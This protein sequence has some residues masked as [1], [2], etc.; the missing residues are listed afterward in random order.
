MEPFAKITDAEYKVMRVVWDLGEVTS[1]Q[2]IQEVEKT[3]A[4]SPKTV[5]TLIARLVEKGALRIERTEG[6]THWYAAVVTEEDYRRYV[7]GSVLERLYG[8]S[9][10]RMVACF[11]QDRK[12]SR[13]EIR[14]LRE[15]LEEEED[16]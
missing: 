6:R 2:I 13:E 9:V 14:Q 7:S 4:W 3:E 8:N 15:L 1:A 10:K 11:L 5:Y 16:E 12:I